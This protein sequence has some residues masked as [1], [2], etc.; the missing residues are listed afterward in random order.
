MPAPLP[1]SPAAPGITHE[2]LTLGPL[3]DEVTALP[4]P[5]PGAPPPSL[6]ERSLRA[7]TSAVGHFHAVISK[8]TSWWRKHRKVKRGIGAG[9]AEDASGGG[10]GFRG[11][12]ERAGRGST[13]WSTARLS[14]GGDD[15]IGSFRRRERGGGWVA[16]AGPGAAATSGM[17][18]AMLNAPDEFQTSPRL[19]FQLLLR[20]QGVVVTLFEAMETV[21]PSRCPGIGSLP[22]CLS[23]CAECV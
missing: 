16:G 5:S 20:E 13:V 2:Q 22:A 6:S 1:V 12:G 14:E 3:V 4:K 23:S 18:Q 15:G 9:S 7:T 11:V 17:A 21:G 8:G 10:W 19:R